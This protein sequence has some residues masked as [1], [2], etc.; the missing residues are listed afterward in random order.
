M[1]IGRLS[2]ELGSVKLKGDVG[3]AVLSK[4]M[5]AMEK[6]G[7]GIVKM[8]DAAAMERSV[9]PHIGSNLDLLV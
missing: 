1:D 7:E 4:N 5:D 6:E 2:S 8:I 9:H 3:V